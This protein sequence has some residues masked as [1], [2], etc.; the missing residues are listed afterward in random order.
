MNHKLITNLLWLT[1][2]LSDF[3]LIPAIHMLPPKQLSCVLHVAL[4]CLGITL[5]LPMKSSHVNTFSTAEP[6]KA[7]ANVL[8]GQKAHANVLDGQKAQIG[9]VIVSGG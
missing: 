6:A 2:Y 7:H 5:T 8:N 3:I 9:S 1:L 4:S